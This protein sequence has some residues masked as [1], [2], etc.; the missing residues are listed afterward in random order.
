MNILW[1][2][3]RNKAFEKHIATKNQEID[4]E[5]KRNGTDKKKEIQD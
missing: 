5:N 1:V 2:N 3:E 4:E